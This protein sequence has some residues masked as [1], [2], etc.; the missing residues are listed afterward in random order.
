MDS[1]RL[2]RPV[3]THNSSEPEHESHPLIPE[4]IVDQASQRLFVVSLFVLLQCW[5]IYDIL[6]VKADAF[7][8]SST[9]HMETAAVQHFTSLNNFTFV[10]KYAFVDGTFLWLLPVLNIP[11]LTF[12]PTFTLLLTILINGFTFVLA[13]NAALPFLS[14]LVLPLWN[15]VS[16]NKE[17]TIMGDSATYQNVVNVNEHFKGKYTIQYLPASS[18]KLNPFHFENMCIESSPDSSFF[19]HSIPLPIEFNTTS[20][21]DFIQIK[22]ISPSNTISLMNYTSR[23]VRKLAKRDYSHLTEYPGYVLKDDRVFYLEV[24]VTKPGSYSIHNVLDSDGMKICPYKSSFT[25]GY[26]PTARFSY[27]GLELEYLAYKCIGGKDDDEDWTLPLIS[28]YGVGPLNVEIAAISNGRTISRFNA[29]ISGEELD[30]DGLGWLQSQEISRNGL[31]QEILRDPSLFYKAKAGTLE[32]QILGVSDKLGN[33]RPYNPASKDKDVNYAIQLKESAEVALVDFKPGSPLLLNQT[34]TLYFQTSQSLSPSATFIVQFEDEKSARKENITLTFANLDELKRGFSVSKPGRYS[35][36]EGHDKFCPC[37]VNSGKLISITTPDPPSVSIRGLPLTDKCVGTVG[38]EFT[39]SFTGQPPFEVN[40]NV[41]KNSSGILRPVLNERGL[42]EHTKKSS[43]H[44]YQFQYKPRQE[45]SYV[46]VFKSVKDKYYQTIPVLIPEA[47]NTFATYFH[48]RSK[49]YIFDGT[50]SKQLSVCKGGVTEIPIH[51]EG[52]HPFAFKYS[53][54]DPS[55]KIVAQETVKDYFQDS[56]TIRTPELS[57]RGDFQVSITEVSDNLGCPVESSENVVVIKARG[58]APS[59]QF[60]KSSFHQIIEG[61]SVSVPLKTA[62]IVG[63]QSNKLVYSRTG[64]HDKASSKDLVLQGASTLHLKEEGVYRLK[65]FENGGCPGVV[66]ESE[67]ITVLF[68]PKPNITI[69]ADTKQSS[70]FARLE[71]SCQNGIR[72]VT[73]RLEGQKP[74]VIP[75]VV[76]YPNGR[77]RSS[78]ISIDDYEVT[79]PLPTKE[80]GSYL[81]EFTTVYDSLYTQKAMSRISKHSPGATVQYD[82]LEAPDFSVEQQ[83]IQLCERA[84]TNNIIPFKIPVTFEGKYPFT[85]KGSIKKK[86][87]LEKEAFEISN[88]YVPEIDLN[89]A[90]LKHDFSV[91]EHIIQFDEVIDGNGC[92]RSSLEKHN[93]VLVSITKVPS[94]SKSSTKSYYCVGDHISYNM[95][96]VSPFTIFYQFNGQN[97]KTELGFEFQRLASKAGEL[98]IVALQDSSATLCL[99]NF[100]TDGDVFESLKLRVRDLPSVEISH[101]DS[102]IENLNEGD[103]TEITFKFTGVPPFEVTYVRTLGEEEGRHKKRRG[104]KDVTRVPRRIVDTKTIRD[105]QGYEYTEVVGLEGT[106]EAIRVSDAYCSA[107]RDVNEIL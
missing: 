39:F 69:V 44:R 34:K 46:L 82:V 102:I 54:S 8:V 48:Q 62:H 43:G 52:N 56:Y 98:A 20:E 42:K 106:Y 59:A 16:K 19:P 25:L 31:E 10:L 84:S 32:F 96:G 27:P 28:T 81:H 100:T 35:L 61:H 87:S 80:S 86:E 63:S 76:T 12:T 47:E 89:N 73:L 18:V 7:A 51:F 105:I 41:F 3:R 23:N 90:K 5:K 104:A 38:F 74:F 88:V 65:S 53:I 13:S 36:I 67:T 14:G 70:S 78:S 58:E 66:S 1:R 15:A 107:S 29:T 21:V 11:L 45:G 22:H 77:T 101:G 99:V 95:S 85:V 40:Y 17:L 93:T 79:I 60:E 94:I 24:D 71:S 2:S 30:Q 6:L 9:N 91:G 83:Y 92:D 49:Y 33:R 37:G 103:Q 50:G 26:C 57:K 68:A 97:R 64:L 72:N 4:H 75:Y 55:G